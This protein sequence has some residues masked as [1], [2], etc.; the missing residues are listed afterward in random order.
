MY[1][2]LHNVVPGN[3]FDYICGDDGCYIDLLEILEDALLRFH[4][5]LWLL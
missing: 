3:V 5:E 4:F 1:Y 2:V